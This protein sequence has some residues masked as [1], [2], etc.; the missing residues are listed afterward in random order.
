LRA[1]ASAAVNPPMPAPA[2][3]T[4]REAVRIRPPE[5]TQARRSCK[6]HSAGRAAS[7]ARA[8]LWRNSVEQYGQ[9]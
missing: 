3:M 2:T 7:G 9:V 6:A 8:A 4:L 5:A 1:S